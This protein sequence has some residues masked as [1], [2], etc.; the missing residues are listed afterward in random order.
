MEALAEE[1]LR[2]ILLRLPTRDV[3]RGRCVSQQWRSL[4]TDPYFIGVHAHSSHVVSGAAAEALLVSKTQMQGCSPELTVFNVSTAATMCVVAGHPDEY[5]PTNACNG[6]L[7]LAANTVPWMPVFVCNPVTGDKLR[8]LPPLRSGIDSGAHCHLHA[9]GYSPSTRHYKLFRLSLTAH[10]GLHE[11]YVHVLTLGGTDG[12]VWRRHRGLYRCH[13]MDS[14]PA[15]IDHRLHVLCMKREHDTKPN[16][17]LVVDVASERH[18]MYCLPGYNAEEAVAT[19]FDLHGR[20]CVAVHELG[21]RR[22]KL[23]FWVVRP[24]GGHGCLYLS[25]LTW[26]M[27]YSFDMGTTSGSLISLHALTPS[28]AWLDVDDGM[29]YYLYGNRVYKHDTMKGSRRQGCMKV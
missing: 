15:L 1:I 16:R 25:P 29:L 17:L 27:R 21:P 26:E 6:F 18:R 10:D 4:L 28:C 19:A 24:Q 13:G 9:M 8:V 22:G 14:M 2:E 12:G 5:G 20:V 3:G 11:N 7:L 23:Y